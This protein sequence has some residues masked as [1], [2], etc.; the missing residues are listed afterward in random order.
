MDLMMR[1]IVYWNRQI[2]KLTIL[3]VKLAQGAAMF[4]ALTVAKLVPQLMAASI[5]WF[6][7]LGLICGVRP[8]YVIFAKR[9]PEN[10]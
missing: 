8:L 1:W 9:A 6:V 4:F 10:T 7:V 2:R 3:D 5:W